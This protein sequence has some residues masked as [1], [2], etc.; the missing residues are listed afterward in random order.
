MKYDDL[1]TNFVFQPAVGHVDLGIHVGTVQMRDTLRNG[2]VFH[3]FDLGET[4]DSQVKPGLA[5]LIQ[6]HTICPR[7]LAHDWPWFQVDPT[8]AWWHDNRL[9][10]ASSIYVNN[11][12]QPWTKP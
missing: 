2:L 9:C 11:N 12:L 6:A 4:S 5:T 10:P 8:A 3:V 1:P 7:C